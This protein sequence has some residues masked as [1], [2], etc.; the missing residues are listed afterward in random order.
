MENWTEES[1][2]GKV[3]VD[4]VSDCALTS[5]VEIASHVLVIPCVLLHKSLTS[6][7]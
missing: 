7:V 2:I 6:E 3:I 1:L 5:Y 4:H